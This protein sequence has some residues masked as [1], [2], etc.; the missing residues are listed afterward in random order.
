[1]NLKHKA[2]IMNADEIRRSIVRISHEIVE[3]N[4]GISRLILVGIRKRGAP[5]AERKSV[6]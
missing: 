3:A 4:G 6:V 2:I 5:I 1:M